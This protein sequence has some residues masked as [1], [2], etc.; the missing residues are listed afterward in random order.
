M[1]KQILRDFLI[2]GIVPCHVELMSTSVRRSKLMDPDVLGQ[3][4]QAQHPFILQG[5]GQVEQ[6]RYHKTKSNRSPFS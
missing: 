6:Q 4:P 5:Q 2:L 3:G 1:W